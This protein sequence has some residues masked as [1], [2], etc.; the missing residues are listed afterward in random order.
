MDNGN[1][2]AVGK[3]GTY[4][5]DVASGTKKDISYNSSTLTSYRIKPGRGLLLSLSNNP[6]GRDCDIRF[7]GKDGNIESDFN[8]N[9]KIISLDIHDDKIAALTN[10]SIT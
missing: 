7:I 5:I 6:D 10:G 9:S 4:F 3:F 1:V 2:F 8:T